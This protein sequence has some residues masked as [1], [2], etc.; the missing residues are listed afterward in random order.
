MA[1]ETP[2]LDMTFPASA[3]L[4]TKQFLATDLDANGRVIIVAAA[5]SRVLGVLQDKP[6]AIDQ[7]CQI[8]L[9]GITKMISGGAIT[10]GDLV[11]SDNAGKGKTASA[12]VQATG[13]ASNVLGIA[14]TG[15]ANGDAFPVFL[16]LAGIKPTSYA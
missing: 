9:A 15:A 2:V 8:R 16:T 1:Y 6:T 7:G 3:D 11:A 4:S 5:G 12:L 13:A 14:L 10:V